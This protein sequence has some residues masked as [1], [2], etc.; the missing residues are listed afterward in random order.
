MHFTKAFLAL[1][2]VAAPV[3]AAPA[4]VAGD[5]LEAR[6]VSALLRSPLCY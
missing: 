6:A 1:A 3:L 5:N 2:F 4:A